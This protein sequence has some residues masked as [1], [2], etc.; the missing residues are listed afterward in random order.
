MTMKC[1]AC[2]KDNV[3]SAKFCKKCG[4]YLAWAPTT[5][6]QAS[7]FP[8][9]QLAPDFAEPDS[10]ATVIRPAARPAARPPT[11]PAAAVAPDPLLEALA[12]RTSPGAGPIPHPGASPSQSKA[13]AQAGPDIPVRASKAGLMVGGLVL[14][15]MLCVGFGY[16]M[17]C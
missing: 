10:D 5:A 11:A 13:V 3:E 1:P 6:A 7:E 9:T 8:A 16:W 14:M 15:A 2:G 17:F 12:D 4:A